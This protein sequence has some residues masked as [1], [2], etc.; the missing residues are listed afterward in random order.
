MIFISLFIE[1]NRILLFFKHI[2]TL[3]MIMIAINVGIIYV[4]FMILFT[5]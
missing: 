1:Y 4:G 3:I 2:I 5:F